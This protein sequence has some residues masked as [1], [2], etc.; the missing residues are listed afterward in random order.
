MLE[1]NVPWPMGA[2][3]ETYNRTHNILELEDVLPNVC[4]FYNNIQK[5]ICNTHSNWLIKKST[6]TR[7][8]HTRR[9]EAYKMVYAW[10]N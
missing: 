10:W 9:L 7:L 3:S 6:T 5:Y 8:E 2:I 1:L 4:F